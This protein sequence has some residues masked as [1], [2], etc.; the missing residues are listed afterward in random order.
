M[1]AKKLANGK[2]S[3]SAIDCEDFERM[4]SALAGER[5][6]FLDAPVPRTGY[7]AVRA[8]MDATAK[9]YDEMILALDEA[10]PP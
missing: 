3:I 4:I 8:K 10:G 9:A 7:H 2:F 5:R 6:R 1:K